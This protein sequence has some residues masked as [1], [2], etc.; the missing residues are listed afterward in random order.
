MKKYNK[1][2]RKTFDG[3]TKIQ[4]ERSPNKFKSSYADQYRKFSSSPVKEEDFDDEL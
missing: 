4:M 3:V 1:N 2:Q